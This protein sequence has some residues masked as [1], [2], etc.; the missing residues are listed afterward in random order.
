MVLL[1]IARAFGN[2]IQLASSWRRDNTD[3]QDWS[4]IVCQ[5]G[6]VVVAVNLSRQGLTGVIP[7]SF[8]NLSDSKNLNL[9]GNNL[10]GSIPKSFTTLLLLEF[11]DLSYNNLSREVPIFPSKLKLNITNNPLLQSSQFLGE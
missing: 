1:E 11:L 4:F 3:C 10:R 8:A 5:Q 6:N 2:P 7:P 9:S